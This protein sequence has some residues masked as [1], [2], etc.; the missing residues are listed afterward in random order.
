MAAFRCGRTVNL[1]HFSWKLP[2]NFRA[3]LSLGERV[4]IAWKRKKME[5]RESKKEIR[6]KGGGSLSLEEEEEEKRVSQMSL[7]PT[8]P[9][10]TAIR[11]KLCLACG[12]AAPREPQR[13]I[14]HRPGIGKSTFQ[15]PHHPFPFPNRPPFWPTVAVFDYR[16]PAISIYR[17][18]SRK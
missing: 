8:G 15:P 9:L 14:I 1:W 7:R 17:R 13:T 11:V 3:V 10:L 16:I 6:K 2:S 5:S 4:R 12:D 18:L